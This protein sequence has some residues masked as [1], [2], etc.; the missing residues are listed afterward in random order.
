MYLC[1]NSNMTDK[2]NEFGLNSF[3]QHYHGHDIADIEYFLNEVIIKGND[4]MK[5]RREQF[6]ECYLKPKDGLLPSQKIIQVID[7]FIKE[8]DD[9]PVI[10]FSL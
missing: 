5:T 7:N 8:Y 2:F 6:F 4:P 10:K 1:S 3:N 9:E